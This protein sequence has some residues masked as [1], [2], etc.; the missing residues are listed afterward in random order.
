[1]N[2]AIRCTTRT[3]A[4]GEL[5]YL[6]LKDGALEAASW[7]GWELWEGFAWG[8]SSAGESCA[9]IGELTSYRRTILVAH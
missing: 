5:F 7:E 6:A 9:G 4:G 2:M 1:M 8:W 3:A